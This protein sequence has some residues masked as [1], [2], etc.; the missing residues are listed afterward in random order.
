MYALEEYR[1]QFLNNYDRIIEWKQKDRSIQ[2][3]NVHYQESDFM[4]PFYDRSKY[5]KYDEMIGSIRALITKLDKTKP[6][7]L[8]FPLL[9]SDCFKIGSENAIVLECFDEL[10]S[11]NIVRIFNEC[12]DICT[13]HSTDVNII[14]IDDCIYTGKNTKHVIDCFAASRDNCYSPKCKSKTLNFYTLAYG[15]NACVE[16]RIAEHIKIY[17][18]IT[19]S[20]LTAYD[21]IPYNDLVFEISLLRFNEQLRCR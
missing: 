9:K 15:S 14:I 5:V 1:Q 12:N 10:R 21:Y 11:L 18:R 7:C 17:D 6:Y 8:F 20:F 2:K 4:K 3:D 16:R 19:L 13:I